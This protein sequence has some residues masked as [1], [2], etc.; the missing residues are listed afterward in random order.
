MVVNYLVCAIIKIVNV[1][2]L[3]T[4]LVNDLIKL[5]FVMCAC[6]L[7]ANY[8][9]FCKFHCYIPFFSSRDVGVF[10]CSSTYFHKYPCT[11]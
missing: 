10:R 2:V 9:F 3:L 7:V 8:I 11:R 4:Q 5:H 1:F 6:M